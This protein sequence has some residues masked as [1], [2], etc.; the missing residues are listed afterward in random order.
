MELGLRIMIACPSKMLGSK[1]PP[2]NHLAKREDN[3][4]WME[5]GK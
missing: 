2:K 1:A 4:E 5:L 3:M